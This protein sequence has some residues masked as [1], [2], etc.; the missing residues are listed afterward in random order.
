LFIQA[1]KEQLNETISKC[2][3]DPEMESL[4]EKDFFRLPIG[5]EFL[6][7]KLFY[8]MIYNIRFRGYEY[9][10][11]NTQNVWDAVNEMYE[12]YSDDNELNDLRNPEGDWCREYLYEHITPTGEDD[13]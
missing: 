9:I 10:Q 13:E 6:K 5:R 7:R 2:E 4:I 8:D 3:N 11:A 1:K 12:A